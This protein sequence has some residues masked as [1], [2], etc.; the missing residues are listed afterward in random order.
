M[1]DDSN[2][3]TH[4]N[5]AEIPCSNENHNTTMTNNIQ[6]DLVCCYVFR[7]LFVYKQKIILIKHKRKENRHTNV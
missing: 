7:H 4:N 5:A 6:D 3:Y 2:A 1:K